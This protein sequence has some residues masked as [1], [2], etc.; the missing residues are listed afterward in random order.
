MQNILSNLNSVLPVIAERIKSCLGKFGSNVYEVEYNNGIEAYQ[1]KNYQT[2]IK[3]YKNA[4]RL[5]PEKAEVYYNLGLV[6]FAMNNSDEA[7]LNFRKAI[8]LNPNDV[9][10]YYNLGLLLQKAE[11]F[12][13]ALEQ[14]YATIELSNEDPDNFYSAGLVFADMKKFDEASVYISK[15]IE[16]APSNPEYVLGLAFVY[17]KKSEITA[18]SNDIDEAIQAYIN[19]LNFDPA[20]EDINYRLAICYAR[21][22]LW[23]ECVN[24]C[25]KVLEINGN[26]S[27]AYNQ[28]GLALFCKE[29]IDDSIIMF[30][31]AIVI[32]PDFA[33]AYHN[34]G[35]SYEKQGDFKA[36]VESFNKYIELSSPD[37]KD[38]SLIKSHIKALEAIMKLKS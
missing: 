21:K 11:K 6:Y 5:N 35:N 1:T 24:Y 7:E 13:E 18:D 2:A 15:A 4:I 38:L 28:Y 3:S 34:L 8:R 20:S 25:K 31:K 14:F 12:E 16:F 22:G 26:S 27:I 29:E 19:A 9:D 33:S 37:Q 10:S 32:Q 23:D 36:A 17:D 30:R